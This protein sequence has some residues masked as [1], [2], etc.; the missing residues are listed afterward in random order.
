MAGGRP[1]KM[2][3][4]RVQKLEQAFLMGCTDR[5]ACLFADIALNTLYAYCDKHPEFSQRKETL[6]TNPVMK[7][8]GVVLE[9]IEDKDLGAAQELLKRKE[10]SKVALTGADDGPVRIQQVERTIVDPANTNG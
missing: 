7:A 2:T 8:R 6:K 4:A 10:G 3:P 9:A 1:T 5:E